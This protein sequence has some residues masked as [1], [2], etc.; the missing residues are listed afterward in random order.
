MQS[1]STQRGDS[2]WAWKWVILLTA[3]VMFVFV[4]AMTGVVHQARCTS[5]Y[6]SA[7]ALPPMQHVV[8]TVNGLVEQDQYVEAPMTPQ[9]RGAAAAAAR[10][11]TDD[12]CQATDVV[13][14][15]WGR[16][17]PSQAEFER[18]R[19]IGWAN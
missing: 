6:N 10:Q 18:V 9:F 3:F 17:A 16:P 5:D 8:T 1:Q 19:A 12:G 14:N 13:G 4:V 11:L 2:F 15:R 7:V